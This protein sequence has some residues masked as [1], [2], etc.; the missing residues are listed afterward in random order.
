MTPNARSLH[1]MQKEGYVAAIV[2]KWSP[3]PKPFGKRHDLFGFV[4]L[5]GIKNGLCD[6]VQATTMAHVNDRVKKILSHENY[7][8]IKG[9]GA[10]IIVHGWAKRGP[11]GKAK[12]WECKKVYVDDGTQRA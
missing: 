5:I 1:L 10:T 6:L 3:F 11:R 8:V 2:E 7:K 9:S 4:D 12:H